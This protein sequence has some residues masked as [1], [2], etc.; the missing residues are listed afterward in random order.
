MT[1]TFEEI[2]GDTHRVEI[3]RPFTQQAN[4]TGD[5]NGS[6]KEEEN[7]DE[8]KPSEEEEKKE[9]LVTQIV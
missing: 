1:F 7:K 6:H 2:G 5:A 3:E 4:G 9:E 8:S